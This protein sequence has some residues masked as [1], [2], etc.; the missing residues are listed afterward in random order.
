MNRESVSGWGAVWVVAACALGLPSPVVAEPASSA[1]AQL[2]A[3]SAN[4]VDVAAGIALD[5][6]IAGTELDVI[7]LRDYVGHLVDAWNEAERGIV[8]RCFPRVPTAAGTQP[9]A[10]TAELSPLLTG[11]RV[12]FKP[13]DP[14]QLTRLRR[15]VRRQ[16]LNTLACACD[17]PAP[18]AVTRNGAR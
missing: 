18:R 7:A 9:L 15:Y 13:V 5:L 3:A 8:Q 11:V 12:L 4:V 16:Q 10:S 1:C 6:R 17:V 14:A 2:R